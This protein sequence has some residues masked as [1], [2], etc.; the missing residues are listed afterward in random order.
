MRESREAAQEK[1]EEPS[2][3][4]RLHEWQGKLRIVAKQSK[5]RREKNAPLTAR[6]PAPPS[7]TF[8]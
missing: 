8:S 3:V 1:Q 5:E 2:A 4:F 6:L 7:L